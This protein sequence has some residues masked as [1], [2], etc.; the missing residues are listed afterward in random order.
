MNNEIQ[1]DQKDAEELDKIKKEQKET[2]EELA[3]W[4]SGKGIQKQR[5]RKNVV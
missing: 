1:E 3:K 4:E 5:G 2:G